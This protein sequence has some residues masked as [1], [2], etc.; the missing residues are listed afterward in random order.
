MI[1]IN[2]IIRHSLRNLIAKLTMKISSIDHIRL[3]PLCS[4]LRKCSKALII[5]VRTALKRYFKNLLMYSTKL[6][7][8]SMNAIDNNSKITSF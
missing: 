6:K 8:D 3:L 4:N 1:L 7:E 2:L 5:H